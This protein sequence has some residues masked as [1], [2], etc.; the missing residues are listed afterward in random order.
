MEQKQETNI[1]SRK[2]QSLVSGDVVE[3]HQCFTTILST[4]RLNGSELS[5]AKLKKVCCRL[6]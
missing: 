5:C 4:K 6:D 2:V 3:Q 1:E